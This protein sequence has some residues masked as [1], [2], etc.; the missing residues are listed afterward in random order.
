MILSRHSFFDSNGLAFLANSFKATGETLID[1]SSSLLFLFMLFFVF[2]FILWYFCYFDTFNTCDVSIHVLIRRK[3]RDYKAEILDILVQRDVTGFNTIK[4]NGN[5]HPNRLKVHLYELEERG[6]ISIDKS[7]KQHVYSFLTPKIDEKYSKLTKELKQIETSLKNPELEENERT[8][9]LSNYLKLG[10]YLHDLFR[11][12]LL[13]PKGT[14]FSTQQYRTMSN[15]Q[16]R[17]LKDITNKL[18]EF[19]DLKRIRVLSML[20]KNYKEKPHMLS[21]SQYRELT[22]M[23]TVK[24]KREARIKQQKINEKEFQKKPFCTFCPHK[25]KN[26]NESQ[27]H[28]EKHLTSFEKDPVKSIHNFKGLYCDKCGEYMDIKKLD[29]HK[30]KLVRF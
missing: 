10:F 5:F 24:E 19:S 22:H 29:K 9:L 15:F 4:K 1:V 26:Y 6:E 2:L 16:D 27:K 11:I 28:K 12:S 17:I 23:P 13:L 14:K 21:L 3:Q 18:N 20:Q 25:S 7:N 30:C 8:L